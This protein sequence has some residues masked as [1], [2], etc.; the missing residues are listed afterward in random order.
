MH[1]DVPGGT[2]VF[3]DGPITE[4]ECTLHWRNADHTGGFGYS[5]ICR[6]CD[7]DYGMSYHD[8]AYHGWHPAAPDP[9]SLTG[10]AEEAELEEISRKLR[11]Y[12]KASSNWQTFLTRRREGD[13]IWRTQHGFAMVRNGRPVSGYAFPGPIQRRHPPCPK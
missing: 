7:I 13:E 11:H 2:C 4:I 8:G 1:N 6:V 10:I 3:C 9:D 12:P 5:G